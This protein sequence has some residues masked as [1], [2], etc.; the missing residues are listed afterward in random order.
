[1][2]GSLVGM[3]LVVELVVEGVVSIELNA[4]VEYGQPITMPFS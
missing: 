1:V 2:T 4:L 3:T